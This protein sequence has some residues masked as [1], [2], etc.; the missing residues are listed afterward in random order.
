MARGIADGFRA[1]EP[2]AGMVALRGDLVSQVGG[3][4]SQ[5]GGLVLT[6]GGHSSILVDRRPLPG[7]PRRSRATQYRDCAHCED[8]DHASRT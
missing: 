6:P 1:L 4:I 2:H 8:D 5:V 7:F 3:F